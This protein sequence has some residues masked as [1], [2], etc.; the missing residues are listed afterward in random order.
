M[1]V[2]Y[3]GTTMLLFDD[4]KDQVL[5]DCHVTRPSM[6]VC[7][8]SRLSTDTITAER[9]LS[10]FGFDRLRAIFISHSHHDHFRPDHLCAMALK[11]GH[12]IEICANAAALDKLKA[13]SEGLPGAELL[14][15][16][17]LEAN[18]APT[19]LEFDGYT[20]TPLRSN[21]QTDVPGEQTLHFLIEKD[22][23]TVFYGTDGAWLPT[24]TGKYLYGKKL[25][26]YL[27][28]ATCAEHEGEY[29]I[30][31]H[32]T[33]PMIR[34][35]V[36]VMRTKDTFAEDAKLVLVH[37]APSLHKSHAETEVIAAADGLT[38]AYDG[39]ELEI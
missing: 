25:N 24:A 14:V 11:A 30:Y 6:K 12:P 39:M 29:R 20:V 22:G 9:V 32:N 21:H 4:G 7:M 37:L 31:E 38:V 35:M 1:K 26:C 34:M 19:V 13:Q 36:S 28:D 23:K 27:F 2:T 15:P 16:H 3:L 18:E 8:T 33:L 5:F 17:L 10:Q